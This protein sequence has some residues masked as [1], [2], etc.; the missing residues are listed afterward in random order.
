MFHTRY[1]CESIEV[2]L[3]VIKESHFFDM[4]DKKE[5]LFNVCYIIEGN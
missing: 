4:L 1:E 5:I 2:V 3:G